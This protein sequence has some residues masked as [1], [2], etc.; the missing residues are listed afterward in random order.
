MIVARIGELTVTADEVDARVAELRLGPY[1]GLL[2]SPTTAEGRQLRRWTTQVLLTERVLRDHARRHDRP[3][4]P[5][6]PRPLPQS[7]RIELG[8]VLAAVLATSPAAWAAYDLVTATVTV[9]E[10]AVRA[11]AAGAATDDSRRTERRSVVHRFRGQPVNQGRPYLVAR[12]ELPPP[13]AAVVFA[14]PVGAV[15]EPSP[16]HWFTLG[17]LELPARADPAA[18]ALAAARD[19]LTGSQRRQVFAEWTS[20]Q[21]ARVTLMPGFEHPADIRQPDATHH[22]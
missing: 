22:H 12:H 2:P 17:K 20:R 14:G 18:E 9:P 6:A 7:A 13:V 10:E 5:D 3:A 8:S 19:T 1:A 11:Y 16:D 21:V 4:P 15:V